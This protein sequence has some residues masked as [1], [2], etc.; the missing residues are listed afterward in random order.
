MNFFNAFWSPSFYKNNKDKHSFWKAFLR[1]IVVSFFIGIL[2]AILF[3]IKIGKDIPNFLYSFETKISD[4]YPADLV[5]SIKDQKLSKNIP[6]E[7]KLYPISLFGDTVKSQVE[8]N[9][10]HFVVIDDTKEATLGSFEQSGGVV[11]FAKDGV[12]VKENNKISINSYTTFS[13]IVKNV[14]FSKEIIK[15]FFTKVN[16]YVPSIPKVLTLAIALLYT[17]L[18]PIGNAFYLLFVGLIVVILSVHIF[19]RKIAF[20]EAYVLSMYALPS[21]ILLEAFLY[22]LPYVSTIISSIPFFTTMG[23]ILFLWFMFKENNKNK[24]EE[25]LVQ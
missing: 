21:I 7:I 13:E 22:Y 4:G 20:V 23:T 16:E 10:S 8:K 15:T 9:L 25:N 3:Y 14:S 5:I 19:K 18:A 6:G 11:F 12:L 1:L 24:K 17:L 2:Y